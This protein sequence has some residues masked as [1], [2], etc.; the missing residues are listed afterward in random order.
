MR[1]NTWSHEV[2]R[3]S[4]KAGPRLVPERAAGTEEGAH[5]LIHAI[6]QLEDL[7]H[8]ERQQVERKE[9]LRQ[10]PV[11]VAEIVLQVVALVLR[12]P[13]KGAVSQRVR[14]PPGNCRSS[15]KQSERSEEVT[16]WTEALR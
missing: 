10:V 16:N 12:A 3:N 9:R 11:A 8:E 14:T 1:T 6:D 4:R 2:N 13:W 7:V 5:A 15:R